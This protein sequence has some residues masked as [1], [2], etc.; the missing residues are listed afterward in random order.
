M[1]PKKTQ[2]V[3]VGA[4]YAGSIAA[5]RLAW[6]TNRSEV[7][8]TLV[9]GTEQFIERI[10]LHK[11]AANQPVG[12]PKIQ[13]NLR[14]TGVNFIQGW[15]KTIHPAKHNLGIQTEDGIHQLSYDYLFYT[16]GSTFDR[17]S[18]PGVRQNAFV[19][20]PSGERSA[21]MLRQELPGLNKAKGDILIC[22]G[23]ATG[24]ESA[25]EFADNFPGLHIHLVTQGSFGA[26]TNQ[27][28]ATYMQRSLRRRGVSIQDHTRIVEVRANVAVTGSGETI[29]FDLCLWAGGFQAPPL[30][31]ETGLAGNKLGQIQVD[32]TMRSISHPEIYAAGDAAQLVEEPGVPMRM[33]VYTALVT[34]VHAAEC[35]SDIL[36]GKTPTAQPF[37]ESSY[38]RRPGRAAA[39]HLRRRDLLG[40]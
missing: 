37:L 11:F 31:R 22:G 12:Q 30:A 24:I 20:T 9:N 8:I 2:I 34:G 23:G 26:F 18:V 40:G 27:E 36:R 15:V 25:A 1:E 21:Q 28:I 3:I 7:V 10:N 13:A 17:D 14:K 33:S 6:K 38:T 32:P 35:L 16:P 39:S 4:G 5:R 29:P 19:L